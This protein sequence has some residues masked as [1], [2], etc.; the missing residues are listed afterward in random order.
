MS[1]I[2]DLL[3]RLAQKE[4]ELRSRQFLAP[5]VRGG[6]VRTK[7]DGLVYTFSPQPEDFEGWGVFAPENETV[8]NLVEEADFVQTA[9]YLKL[10]PALRA[11][12][13]FALRRKT[14]LAFPVNESDAKQRFFKKASEVEPFAVHLTTEGREFETAIVRNIGGA[15]FFE[16]IDRRAAPESAE[17]L[18]REFAEN[19]NLENLPT[20]N[21]TPEMRICY[22]IARRRDEILLERRQ[23]RFQRP[24]HSD[25]SRLRNA[26][27]FGG[28]TLESFA[29]RGDFWLVEWTGRNGERHSSAIAKDFTVVSAGICL[30]GEDAKFDLQSLVGVVE[31]WD[32]DW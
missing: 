31:G 29:D 22:S 18:R 10:F 8:A 25:E 4:T 32:D 28:G 19:T 13:I 6:K 1:K 16:E 15:W 12:L 9:E 11:H 3:A 20:K 14:W 21:L 2:K 24:K 7:M 26:L 23:L 5:C 17:I 30:S 27:K